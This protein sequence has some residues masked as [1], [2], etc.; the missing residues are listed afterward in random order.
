LPERLS[1]D[2][3]H[4][5][6]EKTIGL[7][8]VR[9]GED[10]GVSEPGGDLYF[11]QEPLRGESLG[12]PRAEYLDGYAAAVLEILGEIDGGH[13]ARTELAFDAV[14]VGERSSELLL[15]RHARRYGE[16]AE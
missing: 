16:R 3:R 4:H 5:I 15:Y 1:S 14:A 7:A 12:D 2:V 8:R 9:H 6:I 10:V 11:P 13:P